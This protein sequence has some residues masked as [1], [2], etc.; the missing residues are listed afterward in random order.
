VATEIPKAYEPEGTEQR[1]YRWWEE[2]GF[3]TPDLSSG[4]PPFSMVLPP[5]NV[6]GSLHMG[7]ALNHTLQDILARWKRMEGYCVLWVPGTDHAGIATQNVVERRLAEQGKRRTDFTREEFERI[8]WDWKNRSEANILQQIRRL[9]NSC[10]WTRLRFTM[11][12]RLSRAVREVFV[13]L[14]E[15]GL[16]YRGEY[17]APEVSGQ[18]HRPLG[19]GGHHP[20][21][22]HAG[23]YRSGRS[24][25]RR[26]LP[27]ASGADGHSAADGARTAGGVRQLRG[28]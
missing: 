24:S 20:S 14:Y 1:I 18:G 17:L 8:V 11:D 6:T 26:A 25:G 16:I 10:D 12:E 13:Q 3:F 22:D 7:H 5:P 15:D 2:Q 19:G 4:R 28:A 23:R 21:R 9:G 27:M